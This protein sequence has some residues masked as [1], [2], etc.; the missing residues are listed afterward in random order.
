MHHEHDDVVLH[1]RRDH[2]V[3]SARRLEIAGDRRPSRSGADP[4]GQDHREEHESGEIREARADRPRRDRADQELALGSDIEEARAEGHRDR[5]SREDERNGLNERLG[6]VVGATEGATEEIDVRGDRIV[7]GKEHEDRADRKREDH[8][9]DGHGGPSRPLRGRLAH[10]RGRCRPRRSCLRFARQR[11]ACYL[12]VRS[13]LGLIAPLL[14]SASALSAAAFASAG[15][16]G[17][18]LPNAMPSFV[19]LKKLSP[20]LNEPL[21]TAFDVS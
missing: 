11:A 19:A 2:L 21:F 3:H 20:A 6:D 10:R 4:C 5:Q 12:T 17:S 7:A 8:G 1:D 18:S 9:S 14:M 13:V 15:T 16:T